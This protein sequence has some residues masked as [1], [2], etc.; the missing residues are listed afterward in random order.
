[1]TEENKQIS[2]DFLDDK[3]IVLK[4]IAKTGAVLLIIAIFLAIF[5]FFSFDW[6]FSAFVHSRKETAVPDIT[7]KS[8]DT[9]LDLLANANLA[10]K[11]AGEE[12]QP[13]LPAGSVVRQLPPA[14]TVVREGKVIRVWLSQG[15]ENIEVPD[16]TGLP[17]RN[18][19]ILIRQ[20]HLNVG[21]KDVAFSLTVEKG[22]I[23]SQTP[24]PLELLQ[25]GDSV[26]L[27]V[28][29]GQPPSTVV[30]MP[31]FRQKKLSDVNNW[32][33]GANME[34][35]IIEDKNSLFP[36]GTVVKQNPAPD[37]EVAPMSELS[38]T[39]STRPAS[40]DEKLHRIHYELPQGKNPNRVKIVVLDTIGEREILNEMRQPG[41]KIDVTVPYGG[42]ATFRIYVD[43]ILVRE[44]EMK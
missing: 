31:D 4:S 6:A 38:I 41:S 10:L 2:D 32:A 29:N 37:T 16:L 42:N 9:A 33:S 34:V 39:V 12:P 17:L 8:L 20:N 11:K 36:N 15:A 30:L 26:D 14:G 44:K 5:A 7:K 43:G 18:A 19:E 24:L 22:L 23:I 21:K 40:D 3:P 35:K 27:V 1:M 25:K 13:E 28:S